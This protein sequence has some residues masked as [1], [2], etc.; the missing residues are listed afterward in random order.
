MDES[1]FIGRC[2]TNVERPIKDDKIN[3][4]QWLKQQC[5]QNNN[6]LVLEFWQ[7][8]SINIDILFNADEN[9]NKR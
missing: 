8:F 5:F 3:K 4:T 9:I 2:P 6:V 1:D 7:Y